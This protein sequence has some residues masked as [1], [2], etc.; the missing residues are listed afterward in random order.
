MNMCW[1]GLTQIHELKSA[2]IFLLFQQKV[3]KGEEEKNNKLVA[4]EKGQK[5]IEE[6]NKE[7]ENI[8]LLMQEIEHA[9]NEESSG[10]VQWPCK[11]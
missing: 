1:A 3:T 10:N 2:N 8:E 4:L 9:L 7:I 5:S 11:W 6:K